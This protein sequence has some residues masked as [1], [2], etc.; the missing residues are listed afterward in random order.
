[1]NQVDKITIDKIVLL[2]KDW[3]N[4]K[5]T[6]SITI[7]YFKGGISNVEFKESIKLDR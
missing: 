2:I 5:K 3:N 4:K 6:G 1:M 7:N